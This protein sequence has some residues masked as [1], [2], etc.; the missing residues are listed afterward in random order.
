MA[1]KAPSRQ[2]LQT[3]KLRHVNVKRFETHIF[4]FEVFQYPLVPV[5]SLVQN[6]QKVLVQVRI[7]VEHILFDQTR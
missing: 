5:A 2:I 1:E 6:H 7:A 4:V 3:R